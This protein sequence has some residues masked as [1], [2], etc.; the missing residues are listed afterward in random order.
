[1]YTLQLSKFPLLPVFSK[2]M[3]VFLFQSAVV[4]DTGLRV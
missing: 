2:V 3:I 4:V 1:M